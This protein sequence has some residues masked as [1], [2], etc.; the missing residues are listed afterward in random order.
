MPARVRLRRHRPSAARAACRNPYIFSRSFLPGAL[1]MREHAS[2]PHGWASSTARATLR[3]VQS[4]GHDD[5]LGAACGAA[6]VECLAGAAIQVRCRS[7]QQQ[8]LGRR[9]GVARKVERLVYA[10]GFPHRQPL[11]IFGRRLVA[12]QLRHF[13]T[14]DV[15]DLRDP[16]RRLVHE[17]AHAA[18]AH[19]TDLPGAL[20]RNVARA[21]RVEIE[22]DRRCAAGHCGFGVFRVGDPAN[23][24][25]HACTNSRTAAAGSPDFIRCSPTRKAVY[26][27]AR[28]F[29]TS[30]GP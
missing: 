27:A 1:S 12:V 14:G 18:H 7:V 9:I 16:R 4:A 8:G 17:H 28:N 10:R 22:A 20:R 30:A 15:R 3:C 26:P 23:F 11:G 2:T 6:P 25:H 5:P 24:D 19:R 29:A 13:Q 21:A